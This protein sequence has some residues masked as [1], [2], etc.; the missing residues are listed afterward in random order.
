MLVG[1]GAERFAKEMGFPE[2]NLLTPEAEKIW[3][4]IFEGDVPS[5]YRERIRYLDSL[6][7]FA[8]LAIDP[9]RPNETVNFIAVDA[10]GNHAAF[11]NAPDTTYVYMTD[12][13]DSQGTFRLTKRVSVHMFTRFGRP[14]STRFPVR[15]VLP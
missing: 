5:V 7:K 10:R 3:R 9:E 2:R 13:M 1:S 8:K 12:A 4:E 15:L 14:V 6:R 11:S